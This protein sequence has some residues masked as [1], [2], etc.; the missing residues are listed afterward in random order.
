MC[1]AKPSSIVGW[2]WWGETA[3]SR[4]TRCWNCK[5]STTCSHLPI[6]GSWVGGF[7][8]THGDSCIRLC[9]IQMLCVCAQCVKLSKHRSYDYEPSDL[10]VKKHTFHQGWRVPCT[11]ITCSMCTSCLCC[12]SICFMK[13]NFANHRLCWE[14]THK[15][16][17]KHES[18]GIDPVG[19]L[20][21]LKA[22]L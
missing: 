19:F 1:S 5:E 15:I 9:A 21:T 20:M 22:P 17:P 13:R 18:H 3:A 11:A 7:V 12:F 14:S 10:T 2:L 6:K 8:V 16:Y 4:E